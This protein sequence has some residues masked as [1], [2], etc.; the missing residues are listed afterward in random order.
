MW[1]FPDEVEPDVFLP[2]DFLEV[3]RF[4]GDFLAA[5]LRVVGAFSAPASDVA[6]PAGS[7]TPDTPELVAAAFFD[8]GVFFVAAVFAVVAVFFVELL[9]LVEVVFFAVAV[10]LLVFAAAGACAASFASSAEAVGVVAVRDEATRDA[11][12]RI[13]F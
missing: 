6:S 7:G 3:A 12:T 4:A 1:R 10:R 2:V 8:A 13:P 5:V 11:V 9:F